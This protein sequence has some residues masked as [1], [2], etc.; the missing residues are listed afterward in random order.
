MKLSYHLYVRDTDV[1]QPIFRKLLKT[2][3]FSTVKGRS[4]A[5]WGIGLFIYKSLSSHHYFFF[6]ID[7]VLSTTYK[8]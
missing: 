3:L 2:R 8:L 5:E 7:T 1:S 4:P 6:F